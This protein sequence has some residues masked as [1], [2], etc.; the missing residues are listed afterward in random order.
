MSELVE[1]YERLTVNLKE[2]CDILKSWKV[3]FPSGV[4]ETLAENAEFR[5]KLAESERRLNETENER[6]V[7]LKRINLYFD[8]Y[9]RAFEKL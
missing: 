8:K 4:R 3:E 6:S 1:Y 2:L 5:R 9:R 7:I